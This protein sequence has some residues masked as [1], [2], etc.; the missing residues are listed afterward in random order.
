MQL[1]ASMPNNAFHSDGPRLARPAGERWRRA[2]DHKKC[3]T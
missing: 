1:E 3:L 2:P